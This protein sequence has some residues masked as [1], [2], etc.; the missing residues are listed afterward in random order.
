M[1]LTRKMLK[2]LG[3]EEDKIDQIIEAHSE[4]VDALKEERDKFKA[5][6]DKVAD[7]QKKLDEQTES[8]R[9]SAEESAKIKADFDK[10]NAEYA[11]FKQGVEAD[12]K[13]QTLS[14]VYADFLKDMNVSENGIAKILKYT[15]DAIELDENGKIKNA[16][17]L[18]K[19][20]TSEWPEYITKKETRGADTETPPDHKAGAMK[21]KADIMKIK[22]AS[23]RQKAIMENPELFGLS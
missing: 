2:A 1:A 5:G 14:K 8:A 4:T 11:E 13:K 7:L 23:E 20:I 10:V 15:S 16:G 17:E 12:K 9:K 3:V 18:K 19:T 21:S 6:A 22:D